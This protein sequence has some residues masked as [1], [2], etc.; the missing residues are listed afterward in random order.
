MDR[1]R[2]SGHTHLLP[3]YFCGILFITLIVAFFGYTRLI[4]YDWF[5]ALPLLVLLLFPVSQGAIAVMNWFITLLLTP[6]PLPKMDYSTGIP[7][8]RR[9]IV[10]IPTVLSGPADVSGLLDSLEI[11]YLAN[12]DDNL[13]FALLTD[14]PNA[15]AQELPEDAEIVDLLAAG[16]EDLNS[17]IPEREAGSLL[18]HAP[19]PDLECG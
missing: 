13:Y 16:I 14:L 4:A 2:R 9:T 5:V 10:V 8:E 18:P 19:V 3:L 17:E 11:R 6:V 15:P 7:A 12:Q 1:I